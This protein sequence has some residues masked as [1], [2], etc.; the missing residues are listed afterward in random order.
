MGKIKVSQSIRGFVGSHQGPCLKSFT[1]LNDAK[2]HIV[3]YEKQ[4]ELL[5]KVVLR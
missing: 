1:T 2:L 3:E 5:K 4:D